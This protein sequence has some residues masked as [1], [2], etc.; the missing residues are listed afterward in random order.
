MLDYDRITLA[1]G[2]CGKIPAKKEDVTL[3]I[4]SGKNKGKVIKAV[5]GMK[6][7]PTSD[8]VKEAVFHKIG[9][10]FDGGAVLDLYAGTGNLG[11]EALSRGCDSAVF[12][13]K[14]AAALKTIKQN[15]HS[16]SWQD[17]TEVYKN[18]AGRA[19]TQ[20]GNRKIKFDLIFLDPPYAHQQIENIVE[21]ISAANLLN[22]H[23]MVVCEHQKN[24]EFPE[25]IDGLY[26]KSEDH[27]GDTAVTIYTTDGETGRSLPDA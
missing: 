19:L 11:L 7:R 1:A 22:L 21:K 15:I 20:L 16:C 17:C 6:T 9:P 25:K 4:I 26:K 13:D 14:S 2:R 8:K 3:R 12:I 10:Y 18:E 27:Y 24:I 23:G 5:P